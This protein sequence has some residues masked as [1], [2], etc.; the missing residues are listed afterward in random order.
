MARPGRLGVPDAAG[1]G[2]AG[3]GSPGRRL[4]GSVM[5]ADPFKVAAADKTLPLAC[6]ES[7]NETTCVLCGGPLSPGDWKVTLPDRLGPAHP[8]CA[9]DSGWAVR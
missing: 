8:H 4:E 1:G 3:G 2:S 7:M 9:G 5:G 6:R